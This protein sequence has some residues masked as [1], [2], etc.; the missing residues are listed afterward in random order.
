MA[1]AEPPHGPSS[2]DS[3]AGPA[4]A[5]RVPA[6][7]TLGAAA[8]LLGG[9]ALWAT[10]GRGPATG[11]A[12]AKRPATGWLALFAG[13][14]ACRE[15][16]PGET[17]AHSRSGHAH[18]LRP[19][20]ESAL[21]RRLDGLSV[22]DPEDPGVTWSYAFRDGRLSVRREAGSQVERFLI[23]YAFGSGRHATT[24][25]SL[26][27]PDPRH[28]TGLE[29]R[30]THYT[31]TGRLGLTPGHKAGEAVDEATPLGAQLPQGEVVHCFR[32]HTTMT[33][34]AD[35]KVLDPATMIP[36]IGC[37]RCHGPARAHVAAARRGSK[38][39]AMPFGLG[40]ATA[41]QQMELCGQCHRYPVNRAPLWDFEIGPADIRVDNP[42]II[43]FQPVGLMQS[44]CY[45]RS[46]GALSCVTCHDPHA[47]TSR[48]R[49]AYEAACLSCHQSPAP[50]PAC[51]V[52]PRADCLRCHMPARDAGQGILFT[53]HWIRVRKDE[54]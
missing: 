2:P 5:R 40:R 14:R 34:A 11:R 20:A 10:M 46:Q 35:G 17:A 38:R 37:E 52:S 3:A 41:A 48:D 36:N 22:P 49:A 53:D 15:C 12:G 21:A 24:F 27:D 43:R 26:T 54:K 50:H 4:P 42:I 45:T 7:L 44:A 9:L 39:L 18:T 29:H 8:L 51:P 13:D 1:T 32:C 23:D 19:A 33:S 28:M 6:A 16:H 47:R 31:A 30:L 25:F